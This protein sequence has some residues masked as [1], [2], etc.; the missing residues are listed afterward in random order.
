MRKLQHFVNCDK[1]AKYI[2][3]CTFLRFD[4]Q[5]LQLHHFNITM[6]ADSTYKQAIMLY[7]AF[8]HSIG[9]SLKKLN[10]INEAT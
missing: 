3:F 8:M 1:S 10:V 2:N 4:L 5:L 6:G 7:G 9:L